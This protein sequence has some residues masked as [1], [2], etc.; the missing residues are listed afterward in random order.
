MKE[1]VTIEKNEQL[2][3]IV[4]KKSI[5][6]SDIYKKCNF[7]KKDNFSKRHTWKVS[8]KKYVS[9]YSRDEGRAGTENKYELPPPIDK[10]LYFGTMAVIKHSEEEINNNNI[11]TLDKTEWKKIYEALMG[12]FEDLDESDESSEEEHIPKKFQ[13]KQGYSKEDGF[14][15][16]DN[17]IEEYNSDSEQDDITSN[18]GESDES[19]E[20]DESELDNEITD[21]INNETNISDEEE[22]QDDDAD[23][24]SL[25]ND[26]NASDTSQKQVKKNKNKQDN[27]DVGSE[28]S[29]EEYQY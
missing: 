21:D 15:V 28:L 20:S 11:L 5:D 14:V 17:E 3:N 16:D 7:R 25:P 26:N 29:E 24:S 2:T 8:D 4:L 22:Y 9:L 6:I 12:G 19:D 18:D 1:F 27:S 10:E 13:T 23:M